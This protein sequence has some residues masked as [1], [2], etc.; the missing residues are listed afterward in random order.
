M[1]NNVTSPEPPVEF[2]NA[3]INYIKRA[4]SSS[5]KTV[6][7]LIEFRLLYVLPSN[8]LFRC[9]SVILSNKHTD[10]EYE[11]YENLLLSFMRA[12]FLDSNSERSN[13]NYK[14]IN[15]TDD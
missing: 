12:T 8:S 7:L 3:F 10:E 2:Q 6:N 4:I 5:S 14:N 15:S 11:C 13:N 9:L 1:S